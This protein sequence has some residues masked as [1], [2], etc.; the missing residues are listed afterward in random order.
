LGRDTFRQDTGFHGFAAAVDL[1]EHRHDFGE[2]LTTSV[3]FLRHLRRI[4]GFNHVED[5]D[6][7]FN[8]IFLEVADAMPLRDFADSPEVVFG[9]LNIIFPEDRD[10]GLHGSGDFSGRAGFDRRHELNAGGQFAE[11]LLDVQGNSIHS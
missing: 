3:D 11:N 4:D 9:F 8:F 2:G 7:F 6:G 5:F 1:D 10:A